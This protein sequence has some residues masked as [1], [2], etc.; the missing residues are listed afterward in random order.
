MAVTLNASTSS[1]LVSTAD[2]SG[3]IEL[4]SNGTTKLTVS[5]SGVNIG[6]MN[7][8]AITAGTAWTYTSGTPTSIPFTGIPSWVQKITIMFAGVST[9]STDNITIQIGDSGGLETSGYVGG[10]Q[11]GTTSGAFSSTFLVGIPAAAANNVSGIV[12]LAKVSG[13]TWAEA[14]C[15]NNQGGSRGT[16]TG[17]YKTL[18]DTLTQLAIALDST[19]SF[20]AGT[21]NILYEG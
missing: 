6:Q 11:Y 1:G 12:T 17:G 16:L 4:Q 13:N 8:G 5:S 15:T 3:T 10:W 21:I 2:T 20:D 9:T 14:G 18:S 7:G 19:G